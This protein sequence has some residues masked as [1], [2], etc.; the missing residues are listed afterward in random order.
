MDEFEEQKRN[1]L[2]PI[3]FEAGAALLDCQSFEFGI[4]YLLYLY[5]R[6]GMTG[7]ATV[8]AESILDNEEKKTAGQLIFM[9]KQHLTVSDGIEENLTI[10]LQA[11]NKLV[12]RYLIE[13]VERLFD[14]NQH[15]S[16]VREIRELR[17]K[18]RNSHHQLAPFV[19]GLA[20]AL[21]GIAIDEWAAEAKTTFMFDTR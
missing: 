21:D 6:C 9:L 17:S 13:N 8:R 5:S 10:A 1:I 11:R 7:L 2:Q 19:K 4:A 14:S 18:V 16:L 12:H 20:E 3:Y 15:D